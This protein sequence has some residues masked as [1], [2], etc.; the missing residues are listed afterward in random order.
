MRT[1]QPGQQSHENEPKKT[2]CYH[3]FE[4]ESFGNIFSAIHIVHTVISLPC[5][6][7]TR[8]DAKNQSLASKETLDSAP[9]P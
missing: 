3:I 5:P 2:D 9:H 1:T 8:G 4:F 7:Y 6:Y